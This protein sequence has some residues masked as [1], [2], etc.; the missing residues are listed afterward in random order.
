M[1]EIFT[2]LFPCFFTHRYREIPTDSSVARERDN[3]KNLGTKLPILI[4]FF[5]TV[6]I[7]TV[8]IIY[9]CSG[10]GDTNHTHSSFAPPLDICNLTSHR[11]ELNLCTLT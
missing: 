2:R 3:R 6:L 8:L 11:A 7:I 5:L 4:V 10:L 9:L 1:C